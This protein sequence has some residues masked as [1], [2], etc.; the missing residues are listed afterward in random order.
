MFD[1]PQRTKALAKA[2]KMRP[3][4]EA[5]RTAMIADG[6]E[7][8]PTYQYEPIEAATSLQKPPYKAMVLLR[9][10]E[11]SLSV[12]HCTPPRSEFYAERQMALKVDVEQ[13][14]SWD[15]L[16]KL[17]RTCPVCGAEDVDCV[18]VGFAN[19]ACKAC[20]PAE[21]KRIEVPGW[22]D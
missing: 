7:A 3:F 21:R 11:A 17:V 18:T 22:C 12:W 5:W 10:T 9:E 13:P 8:K 19:Q 15:Y 6:W 2:T 1:N 16:A 4:V 14:Y 20:E